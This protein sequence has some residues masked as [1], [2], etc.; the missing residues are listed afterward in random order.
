M[1]LIIREEKE[2]ERRIVEE[3]TREAF[4]D[5]FQPGADE[6][7]LLHIIRNHKDYIAPLNLVLEKDG[8]VMG[9]IIYTHSKIVSSVDPSLEYPVITF[10]PVCIAKEHQRSGY[11]NQLISA[12][13]EKARSLGFEA[14]IIYGD[15]RYYH[16]F[17]FR[18][19]ERFDITTSNGKFATSLMVLP[20]Q[21][22][23]KENFYKGKFA[24]NFHES[25]CFSLI[26]SEEVENFD[27][28]FPTKEKHENTKTQQEF[29]IMISLVY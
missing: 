28:T 5:N 1:S 29:Q 15:P 8:E 4:W 2:E 25:E 20:L 23:S 26:T 24:G 6:H 10:G 22:S 18:C 14:I 21:D 11:G 12:S 19:G 17:G 3:L 7:Y 13:I 9:H 27:S 16:R